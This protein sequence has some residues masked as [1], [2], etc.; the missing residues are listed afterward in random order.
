MARTR[1]RPTPAEAPVTTTTS[2]YQ[3]AIAGPVEFV[4]LGDVRLQL[5]VNVIGQVAVTQAVMPLLRAA[6]GREA[7]RGGASAEDGVHVTLSSGP[8]VTELK[9]E[10]VLL[11]IGRTP[12]RPPAR[13]STLPGG[14]ASTWSCSTPRAGC[15]WTR[16]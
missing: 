11:A 2:N 16:S 6:Q 9:V 7:P 12:S 8:Q 4:P 15:T 13:A 10:L 14:T 1:A 5:E 3:I